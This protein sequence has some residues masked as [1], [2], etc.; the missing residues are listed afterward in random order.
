MYYRFSTQFQYFLSLLTQNGY[1]W[2]KKKKNHKLSLEVRN[3]FSVSSRIIKI[4]YV[5]SFFFPWFERG[6]LTKPTTMVEWIEICA[7]K[8]TTQLV[9][10]E[11]SCYFPNWLLIGSL[12]AHVTSNTS[13]TICSI[14]TLKNLN[15]IPTAGVLLVKCMNSNFHAPAAFKKKSISRRRLLCH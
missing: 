8:N 1:T 9:R 7:D 13:C 6:K 11:L 15:S 10:S 12:S 2:F 3:Q 4:S 14:R 5:F